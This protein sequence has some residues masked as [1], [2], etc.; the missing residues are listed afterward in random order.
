MH[1][2]R[3]G[4][5]AAWM[6]RCVVMCTMA[7]AFVGL[8]AAQPKDAPP[9]PDPTMVC[10]MRVRNLE[11]GVMLYAQKHGGKLPPDLYSAMTAY[12][13]SGGKPVGELAR[14]LS[15]SPAHAGLIAPPK[16]IDAPWVN[17][18]SSYRYLG[19]ADV[20]LDDV[21]E[22]GEIVIA[23]LRLEQ[24][25]QGEPTPENPTG[26]TF[27]L[28]FLDGHVLTA[29][30]A[31]A[32]RLIA[33]SIATLDALRD[34]TPLPDDRQAAQNLATI[35]K[36]IHAYAKAHE[37]RL[38][39]DLGATLAYVPRDTKATATG[40]QR[41]WLYLSPRTRTTRSVPDEP[42]P[43]WVNA[44]TWYTYLGGEDLRLEDIP[45]AYSLALAHARLDDAFEVRDIEGK[46]FETVPVGMAGGGASVARKAYV[47]WI[48]RESEKTFRAMRTGE[49]LPGWVHAMRD[50][51]II[52]EAVQ[53]YA[54]A[55][56]GR[57]PATL[58]E[59]LALVP[60]DLPGAKAAGTR[61]QIYLSPRAE[62]L[63]TP[64]AGA[65]AA[66]VT[67]NASYVYITAPGLTMAHLRAMA[68]VITVY[69]PLDEAYRVAERYADSEQIAVGIF[70]GAWMAPKAWVE[71]QAKALEAQL[72]P[73][74]PVGP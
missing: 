46:K 19:N 35:I 14:S 69:S 66:W 51:R 45:E 2:E 61:A 60:E 25:H 1:R 67:A 43:E 48:V 54:K 31:E 56:D 47:E 10:A 5:G 6:P 15:V 24:G 63:V 38:P 22:W 20:A 3:T 18:Q 29:P 37:G 36:A 33:K 13:E 50:V 7:L 52:A 30:R 68:N 42:T 71:E 28:A 26:E 39:P 53:A 73:P 58:G 11:M 32:E 21:Q 74:A 8:C 65:D 70:G 64:P 40:P 49:P 59:T 23:H 55:N 12:A 9:P 57:L 4:F 62:T 17:E 27:T 41:A 16:E 72:K 44:N 34:G